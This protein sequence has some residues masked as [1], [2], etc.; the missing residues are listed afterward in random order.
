MDGDTTVWVSAVALTS[1]LRTLGAASTVFFSNSNAVLADM[2]ALKGAIVVACDGNDAMYA[3]LAAISSSIS[4]ASNCSRIEPG[5][6]PLDAA[7]ARVSMAADLLAVP[8]VL[9]CGCSTNPPP[10]A[11]KIE[12][13]KNELVTFVIFNFAGVI[14]ISIFGR[15]T[16]VWLFG[17]KQNPT[18]MLEANW[19]V[20]V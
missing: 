14:D 1:T 10:Q 17:K 9:G 4:C 19:L 2:S 15:I 18:A 20:T 6:A 3:L 8:S 12:I 7:S 5:A 11:L 16:A 13:K